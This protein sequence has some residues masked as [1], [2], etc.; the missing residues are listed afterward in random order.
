MGMASLQGS[1]RIRPGLVTASW[2][3]GGVAFLAITAA[4]VPSLAARGAAL[5]LLGA[6]LVAS[7]AATRLLGTAA[8]GRALLG[9]VV[10]AGAVLAVGQL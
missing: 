8:L 10:G 3:C 2:A 1:L 4:A 6:F 9:A 7:I 5:A